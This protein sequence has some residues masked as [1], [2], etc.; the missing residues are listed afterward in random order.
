MGTK[1]HGSRFLMI[2]H[3]ISWRQRSGWT[4]P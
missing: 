4:Q 2:S 3:V 1:K